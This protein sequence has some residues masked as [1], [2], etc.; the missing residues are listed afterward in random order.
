MGS[1]AAIQKGMAAPS[2]VTASKPGEP[3][4]I[5][6][7]PPP[8]PEPYNH[9]ATR[10][11]APP[12][13][14]THPCRLAANTTT[15]SKDKSRGASDGVDGS[16]T[17]GSHLHHRRAEG[18]CLQ[19]RHGLPSGRRQPRQTRP[20]AKPRPP[21]CCTLATEPP[22]TTSRTHRRHLPRATLTHDLPPARQDPDGPLDLGLAGAATPSPMTMPP[23][24]ACP[25]PRRTAAT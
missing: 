12:W 4:G 11:H 15:K 14:W 25:R 3:T 22:S 2:G 16:R 21:R 1:T 5:S 18:P 17:G 6:P 19:H 24:R 20:P 7:A 13:S 9:L 23:P 8:E 10:M